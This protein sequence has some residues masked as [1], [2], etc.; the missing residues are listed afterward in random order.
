MNPI[1]ELQVFDKYLFL[2]QGHQY[3]NKENSG[4]KLTSCTTFLKRFKK[5]FNRDFW[6]GKKS[7]Q[8]GISRQELSDEWDMKVSIGTTRGSILHNYLENL[9]MNRK[10]KQSFNLNLDVK[11]KENFVKSVVH[12][13]KLGEKFIEDYKFL[14]PV[15]LELVV[16]DDELGIAGQVD[17]LFYNTIE[18]T[19]WL[20]DYKTDKKFTET[21]KYKLINEFSFLPDCE[22]SKYS[23]Q[24]S[25][26]RY[27]IEKNTNIKIDKSVIVWFNKDEV[28]Y[29][30]IPTTYYKTELDGIFG[31]GTTV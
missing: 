2:E 30:V 7:R 25:I 23:L 16:G 12:I 3:T 27:I 26:Y 29:K 21:S 1:V 19:Y 10:I 28:D 8:L 6:L 9:W 31:K 11:E 4:L 5:P 13:K 15:R 22:L 20:I 18:D 17:G 24:T 14:I